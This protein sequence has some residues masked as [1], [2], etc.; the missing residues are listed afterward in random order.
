[1]AKILIL[2]TFLIL[3]YGLGWLGHFRLSILSGSRTERVLESIHLTGI[4]L[5]ALIAITLPPITQFH[6]RPELAYFALVLLLVSLALFPLK[7]KNP[8]LL[9]SPAT[10]PRA[11]PIADQRRSK[12]PHSITWII[13]YCL[14][15]WYVGTIFAEFGT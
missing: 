8:V 13:A 4:A 6:G 15:A 9:L 1:M 11:K 10:G 7:V 5:L 2:V 12:W 14:A 3:G